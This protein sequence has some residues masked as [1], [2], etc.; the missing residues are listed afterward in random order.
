MELKLLLQ[1]F[2]QSWDRDLRRIVPAGV[3]GV[4][5]ADARDAA[6]ASP[7]RAVLL[8]GLNEVVAARRAEAAAIAEEGPECPLIHA[9]QPDQDPTRQAA[10]R[11]PEKTEHGWRRFNSHGATKTYKKSL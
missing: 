6:P 7:H 8:H 5:A 9:H 4:A 2:T 11:R 3:P 1:L 10:A